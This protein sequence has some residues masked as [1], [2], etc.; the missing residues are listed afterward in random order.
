MK[1]ASHNLISG[2]LPH[3]IEGGV[4]SLQYADNIVLFL[5]DDLEKANNL[6]CYFDAMSK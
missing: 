3:V 4:V 2:L 5:E 1:A 6:K